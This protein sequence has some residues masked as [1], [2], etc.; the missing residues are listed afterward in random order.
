MSS[1]EYKMKHIP[2]K[3]EFRKII[4]KAYNI[5]KEELHTETN[6]KFHSLEHTLRVVNNCLFLSEKLDAYVDV[7]VLAAIFHDI[8]R[9]VESKTGRCHAE[10]GA[11]QAEQ[12]LNQE[13]L[14]E[15]I[16]DVSDAIKSHRFSKNIEPTTLEA[17][18]LQD[19]DTLDA[20][21][22]T[23]LYRTLGFSFERGLDLDESIEHFHDK[24]LKLSSRMHFSESNKLAKEKE[25]ILYDFVEGIDLDKEVSDFKNILNRL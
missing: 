4:S 8:G 2:T 7:V 1:N 10:V 22:A 5:V 12:F 25:K 14:T 17:K 19:A 18:I 23:G 15:L 9:P 16:K 21:G 6:K 3:S 11:E 13:G 20:L 24:L